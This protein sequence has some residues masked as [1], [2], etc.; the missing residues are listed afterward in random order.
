[1]NIVFKAIFIFVCSFLMISFQEK[2]IIVSLKRQIFS[3]VGSEIH[4][5]EAIYKDWL[6]D[7]NFRG[8]VELAH[9]VLAKLLTNH[10]IWLLK[11]LYLGRVITQSDLQWITLH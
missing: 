10:D 4:G 3:D 5:H 6:A 8:R 1:M 11:Y 9:T 2:P 7:R